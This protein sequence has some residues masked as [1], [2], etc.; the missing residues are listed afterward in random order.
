MWHSWGGSRQGEALLELYKITQDDKYLKAVKLLA[1]EF[2]PVLLS[3]G[4][5]YQISEYIML[6]PQI[7]YGVEPI[8]STLVKL[9]SVSKDDN[10]AYMASLFG[11]F[12]LKR[13]TI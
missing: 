8:I 3:L 13:I 4:P 1:D 9:Y 6:Y 11:G 2:Y 10:Y 5:V 7:A 12:F